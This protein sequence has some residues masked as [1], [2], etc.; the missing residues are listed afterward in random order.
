MK[1]HHLITGLAMLGL[2]AGCDRATATEQDTARSAAA[3]VRP[4]PG[5]CPPPETQFD[6]EEFGAR[7]EPLMVPAN[8]AQIAAT[9]NTNL[10]ITTLAGGQLCKDVSWMNS[11]AKA[12]QTFADGRFVAIGYDAYEAFGTLVF[13]RA[14][15]GPVLDTGNPPVFSPSGRLM[16]G[17]EL[18]ESG[19]GG[20]ESFAIWRVDPA[21]LTEVHRLP[22]DHDLFARFDG[23][24]DFQVTGWKGD[25]CLNIHGFAQDD[26]SA[27]EW[28]MAK[29]KRTPFFAARKGNWEIMRGSCP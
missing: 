22:A 25:D 21:G 19:Y 6:P 2:L 10:A 9:D 12:A 23:V 26:L 29:A 20:L 16:A 18:T 15:A 5:Q 17:L 7:E 3:S 4:N 27:V 14:G 24:R 8:I 28:D 11:F 1:P 13:D